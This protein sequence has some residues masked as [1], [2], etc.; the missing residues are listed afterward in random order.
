MLYEKLKTVS[1]GESSNKGK[2]KDTKKKTRSILN[3]VK[4][5]L[6]KL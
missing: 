6:S 3:T 1:A 2:K 5:N 4:K